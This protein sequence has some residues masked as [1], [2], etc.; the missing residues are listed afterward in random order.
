MSDEPIT[1]TFPSGRVETLP[2]S[3]V[4][5]HALNQATQKH[6][7]QPARKQ[8]CKHV[9]KALDAVAGCSGKL[10][11]ATWECAL[12][13]K[14]APLVIGGAMPGVQSCRWCEDYEAA[15][16]PGLLRLGLNV[17]TALAKWVAAGSPVRSPARVKELLAICQAC[18]FMATRKNGEKWCGKCGCPVNNS[19]DARRNKLAMATEACPLDPPRWTAET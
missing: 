15:P 6:Q 5:Q 18:P 1:F 4:A 17:T 9:G 7:L 12:H 8:A 11:A 13:G 2:R 10:Q 3:P 19:P 14:C 16:E